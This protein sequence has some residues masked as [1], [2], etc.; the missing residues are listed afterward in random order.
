MEFVLPAQRFNILYLHCHDAGCY[1]EPY[2]H[3]VPAPNLQR[4]A[5]QGVMFRNAFAAAPTCSPSR[6]ALLTGQSPHNAGMLG[7]AHYG[8]RLNDYRQHL[9]HCLHGAGYTSLL[10]GVQHI[11]DFRRVHTGERIG[12][13]RILRVSAND[14][15]NHLPRLRRRVPRRSRRPGGR[16]FH[17]RR[18][19]W[20]RRPRLPGLRSF[21]RL[22]RRPGPRRGRRVPRTRRIGRLRRFSPRRGLRRLRPLRRVRRAPGAVSRQLTG[23]ARVALDRSVADVAADW[24][25]SAAGTHQPFFL[26]VGLIMPHRTYAR[27]RPRQHPAEDPRFVQPPLPLPDAPEVRRDMADYIASVRIMDT[28]CGVV[29]DALEDSGLAGDTLVIATTD[30]GIAFPSIKCTLTDHGLGVYLIMR[31]PGGFEGGR[32]VEGMVSQ[33]DLYP[34]LCELLGLEPPPWLQGTSLMPLVR[35]EQDEIHDEL[36]GEVTYHAAYEPMR[37]IRTRRWKYI[38]RFNPDLSRPVLRNIDAGHTKRYLLRHGL[39]RRTVAQEYLFDLTFDPQEEN[40][41]AQDPRY[42][43]IQHDLAVRLRA[44]M[45][46][47]EDPLLKG[48]V[49]PLRHRG[50]ARRPRP[51]GS[52]QVVQAEEAIDGVFDG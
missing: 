16:A 14:L 11:T 25:R 34:T 27:A 21:R 40:N 32:V 22:R 45:E 38:R 48:P 17:L 28:A 7:L 24:L 2:G 46:R 23:G 43:G 30:H 52:G 18:P 41:L 13:H 31:G 6:A 51:A 3:R 15:R 33:L 12:Y 47:T 49:P 35:G 36:Y 10:C 5:E 8:W 50:R 4:L 19:G 39:D 9:I 42:A 44:W 29:L 26:S 37:S 1:I 20:V